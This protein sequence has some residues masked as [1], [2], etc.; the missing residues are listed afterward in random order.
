MKK[1][2]F[3]IISHFDMG[4]AERVAVNI[5]RSKTP[6]F[7][8]HIVEVLRARS[9]FTATFIAE[10]REAGIVYHRG[11]LPDVRFHFLFERIAALLF[12]L[13]FLFTFLRHR[14]AVIHAHTEAA[15]LCT[16]AFFTCF[17]WLAGHCRIVRTI[18]NTRL[19]TGQLAIGR[20][21][22][23][24]YQ[25][26]HSNVAISLSVQDN[27]RKVYG[28]TPHIIYNGVAP[29]SQEPYPN[30][31]AGKI[32]VLF[33]GRFDP[34]KGISTLIE[35]IRAV[36]ADSRYF[37]HVIGDGPLRN[38]LVNGLNGLGNVR[39]TPPVFGLSRYLS[40]FDYMIM[41]SEFEG[42]SIM[43]IEASMARLPNII[44]SCLGL[45]DTLP[46]DWPLAVNDNKT[47]DFIDIFRNVLP[48]VSRSAL[49]DAAFLFATDHFSLRGMQTAY[50]EVYLGM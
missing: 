49:A 36:S 21:V 44:N 1:K 8:Y 29:V 4:G 14:P 13:T 50:E 40:S 6:E 5:A 25:R 39:I 26:H 46:A 42:L 30:L 9:P 37:F 32:N 16:F 24:F 17:P 27:Y 48:A 47:D 22:E 43:S 33:A 18:H 35:I 23:R 28:E 3:H 45:K 20:R 10:M 34:Q 2:V 38:D 12:P 15:D 31:V 19:W 7:E 41:P 11:I